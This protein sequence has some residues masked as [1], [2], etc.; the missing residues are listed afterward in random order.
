VARH[1]VS[2]RDEL[3]KIISD[4]A[5]VA[6][7]DEKFPLI[8]LECHGANDH[9]K[10]LNGDVVAWSEISGPLRELN[11]AA[12]NQLTTVWAACEGI[13]SIMTMVGGITQGNSMRLV[14]GPG[15]RVAAGKLMD[16]MKSFYTALIACPDVEAAVRAAAA[17]EPSIH[18]STAEELFTLAYIDVIKKTSTASKRASVEELVTSAKTRPEFKNRDHLHRDVKRALKEINPT[19]FFEDAKRKFFMLDRFPELQ[20]PLSSLTFQYI[21]ERAKN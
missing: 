15:T 9:L 5:K 10:L 1:R 20:G 11:I 8:H 17:V 16:A 18:L 12:R 3:V 6:L 7:R 14:I 19:T 13:Y 21:Q 4:L 2:N